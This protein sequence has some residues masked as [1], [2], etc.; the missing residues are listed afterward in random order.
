MRRHIARYEHL[1]LTAGVAWILANLVAC[2]GPAALSIE[3]GTGPHPELPPARHALI[4]NI[5]VAKAVGWRI[6][7]TPTPAAGTVVTRAAEWRRPRRG[8][9]CPSAPG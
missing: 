7:A 1:W 4:P 9:Q 3:A 5:N 8:N 6:G 2:S